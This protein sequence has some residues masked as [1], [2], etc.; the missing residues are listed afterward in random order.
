MVF[1][2]FKLINIISVGWNSFSTD[3]CSVLFYVMFTNPIFS[4]GSINILNFN[5]WSICKF[6]Y[7]AVFLSFEL[8]G[9]L[10]L[11]LILFLSVSLTHFQL[12]FATLSVQISH[13]NYS[14]K[15]IHPKPA[16]GRSG[17]QLS[18]LP[19]NA[20]EAKLDYDRHFHELS[21]LESLTS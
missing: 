5:H 17:A 18:K 12:H 19:W 13:S 15:H 7:G 20:Q 9:Y 1:C 21:N 4:S 11:A 3:R 8:G 14:H 6:P 16:R 2:L 10:H